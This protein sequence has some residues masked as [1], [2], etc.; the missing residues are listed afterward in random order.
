MPAL[1]RPLVTGIVNELPNI[2]F[3]RCINTLFKGIE[4]DKLSLDYA[5]IRAKIKY[6]GEEYTDFWIK[7]DQLEGYI[8]LCGMDSPGLT[9]APAVA[10]YVK[11]MIDLSL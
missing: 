7:N 9:S 4:E 6:K 11:K 10:K 5:G 8:E 2:E 3:F 1:T